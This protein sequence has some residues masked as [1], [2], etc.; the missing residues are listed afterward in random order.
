MLL[1]VTCNKKICKPDQK[2]AFQSKADHPRTEY[3]RGVL[4]HV[5]LILTG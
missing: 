1:V 3:R 5:T 2:V 4:L